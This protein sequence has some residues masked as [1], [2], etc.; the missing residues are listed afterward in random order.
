MPN[1]PHGPLGS[2]SAHLYV[3]SLPQRQ[4]RRQQMEH[5]R[6]IQGLT[7]T[8]VDAV[9]ANAT[10]ANRI[11]DW[12]AA[13][14]A[15]RAEHT[16][17]G[18]ANSMFHWPP[19]IDALAVTQAPLRPLGSDSWAQ[20][21]PPSAKPNLKS[22]KSA[23]STIR[24]NLTCATEDHSI[25]A[26][27]DSTP[28]WM[29]LSPAK[30]AC[31]L[32]HISAIRRF[33]DRAYAQM[34]DVAFILEDDIDM[35]KDIT[36]RLSEVWAVLPPGWDTVFLGHCWSN[37]SFYPALE[38][39]THTKLHPSF[40]PKCTHAYALSL[41]G[42]RRLLQH[43]RYPPFAYSRA[44]DQAY[45]WLIQTGRLRSYSVV[46]SVVVQ[47]KTASSDILP[48]MGSEWREN[49]QDGVFGF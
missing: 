45:A 38:S 25:P 2:A 42:A 15:R 28:E 32:S 49:L 5:L 1:H 36:T 7:W 40:A 3:I 27:T 17:T 33:V 4:D 9:P 46:P 11:L 14:R 30:T 43:L 21:A 22:N 12:V 19:E 37:E 26:L 10:S 23:S 8:I 44:L 34:D 41:P 24:P 31:W 6:A 16:K 20:T 29:K 18:G 39:P 47:R 48:G 13:E 35:E